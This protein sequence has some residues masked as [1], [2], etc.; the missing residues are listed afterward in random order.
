MSISIMS[1]KQVSRNLGI[2]RNR[3]LE[4]LKKS[5]MIQTIGHELVYQ[6]KKTEKEFLALSV[7]LVSILSIM[8]PCHL[9]KHMAVRCLSNF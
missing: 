6:N 7:S 5:G 4:L 1:F 2:T 9:I 8:N 3:F